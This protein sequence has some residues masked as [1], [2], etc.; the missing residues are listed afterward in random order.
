[1]LQTNN[2][3]ALHPI[4][5]SIRKNAKHTIALYPKKKLD[6]KM[7]CISLLQYSHNSSGR[8]SSN[9]MSAR[10][11]NIPCDATAVQQHNTRLLTQ[12]AA[13]QTVL[14]PAETA[15]CVTGMCNTLQA[16]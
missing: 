8:D 14:S 4:L 7:P 10:L 16:C 15:S 1:M 5:P 11:S 6:C 2:K 3:L 12:H 13:T 9:I